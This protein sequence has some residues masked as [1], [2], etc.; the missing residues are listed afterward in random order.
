VNV[1]AAQVE[2]VVIFFDVDNTLL[3]NDAL[4]A[5]LSIRLSDV[6]GNEQSRRFWEIYE[7]IRAEQD[8]V[9][10]TAVRG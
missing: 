5:D 9:D 10:D 2:D 1:H 6:L 7:A 8:Y 3:N 4:K